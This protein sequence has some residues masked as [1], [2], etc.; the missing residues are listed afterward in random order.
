M[1]KAIA[2]FFLTCLCALP[3]LLW[4]Q[5]SQIT[6]K[7]VNKTSGVPVVGASIRIKGSEKGTVTDAQGKFTLNAPKGTVLLI[8]A[9]GSDNLEYVVSDE[10][11]P[12]IGL[13][14]RIGSLEEV[15]VVG[16]G[17]QKKS[18]VTG[19]ISQVKAKDLDD[20]PVSRV[21][22]ALEGRASGL[23]ISTNGGQPGAAS[24][25]MIRG[26]TSINSS[27]PLYVVDG[28]ILDAGGLE[29][30]NPI[31]IESVEVLKD[32][33]STA[34]YGARGAPGVILIT[35]K[36][37]KSGAPRVTYSGYVGSQQPS[38]KLKLTNAEQYA[39]LRNESY[40]A[41]QVGSTTGS[42]TPLFKDPQS[43]GAGTDWQSV[44]MDNHA[45]VEQHDISISGGS[46]KGTYFTSFGYY[47]D[48]GTITPSIS[49]YKRFSFR[50]NANYK[51]KPWINFGENAG[52][53]Y[54]YSQGSLNTNS[55]FGGPLSSAIN[56][57]PTSPVVVPAG[58]PLLGKAPYN[59]PTDYVPLAPN[60]LPYYLS[61]N[62]EQ[63]IT[64][65]A[66][67]VE[68]QQGN[69]GWAYNVLG[70][71]YLSLTPI[72]GLDLRSSINVKQAFY[73]NQSF[74]PLYTLNAST[75]N[76]TQNSFYRE[77]DQT[78]IWS[79][80]NTASYT[81]GFGDHHLMLMVGSSAQRNSGSGVNATL[82]NLPYNT[83]QQ[84]SFNWSL[85]TA[86]H[87]GGGFENQ[88]YALTSLFGRFTYNYQ[89]KYLLTA[90]FRRDGSSNFG[91]NN[92]YGYF[93]S[94]SV[95][96]IPTKENFWKNTKTIQYL[97]LRVGYGV[98]G[99][100]NLP[101]FAYESVIAGGIDYP[102]GKGA[103]Q[104]SGSAP[105]APA[106]PDLK[107]EQTSQF[108]AGFD[109]TFLNHFT[110]S[111]DYFDKKT[112]G[113]LLT[114]TLPG[115]VGAEGAPWANI[116]SLEDHGAEFDL[117]WNQRVGKVDLSAGANFSVFSNKITNLGTN[118]YFAEGSF[119]SAGYPLQR[120]QVGQPLDEFY[121][122]KE[123]G[124]FQTQ[125]DVNNYV[126]KKTGTPIQPNAKPGDFKW[127]DT[128]GDGAITSND[129]T[130][131]GNPT[132]TMNF[133]FNLGAAYHNFD[134]KV[135][136]H[137]QAG[138]KIFMG[139]RRL[140]IANANYLATAM[141]RWHGAG[142]SN[143]YARL[144]D[145]DPND[146]F[147]NPSN[148]YLQNGAFLRIRTLQIGYNVPRQYLQHAGLSNVRIFIG[149]NN[150]FTF[151]KY[152]GY[153]PEIGGNQAKAEGNANNYGVDNV[154]YPTAR[155]YTVGV[156]VG[157]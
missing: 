139:Y 89:E 150:L 27:T 71:V 86:D 157:F 116:A 65:P 95:G 72:K 130:W 29:V 127:Q 106:N 97:K 138:N 1:K 109:M 24:T 118:A 61:T 48:H 98:N 37:G 129:R 31:D 21:E 2:L 17:V 75:A 46:D 85:P 142:T 103:T 44:I 156:N 78:Q 42:D 91:S 38:R 132:P 59:V 10:H 68:T 114:V 35:T 33:A 126:G 123:T 90:N 4:A 110:F 128:D 23:T 63:E 135:F 66:A 22:D 151:T 107:W 82:Y 32:A 149:G 49:N 15:V 115:Y 111:A 140:D 70:N 62:V 104:Q 53:T 64:N 13:N 79:W 25:V 76:T 55:V 113:M 58:S 145:S 119:Q 100:D 99:N 50:L 141:G 112:T 7:V 92:K 74:G 87:V 93:P 69:H 105:A 51:I 9:V 39:T 137:G 16:Y 67:Y 43:L 94:A 148:F 143:T 144:D 147:T 11:E 102:L 133:G 81:R 117:G 30:I 134:I 47:D 153:D 3:T 40:M 120:I 57:D 5:S 125:A 54:S 124:V 20:M 136:A 83:Y 101:P 60:G 6:G 146:N 34:I 121:G 155:S 45:L 12:V 73:G 28:A 84:A 41:A 80:D 131:L 77:N 14:Q 152:Q 18:V 26:I 108:D 36:K 122:F 154:I 56:L 19:A 52:F 96:W 88:P 8:T